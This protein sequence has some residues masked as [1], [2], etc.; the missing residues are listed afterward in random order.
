MI[1]IKKGLDIPIAGAPQQTIEDGESITTVAVLGEEYVGMRPTMHVKVEDRVKK[2]QVLFEDKKNPGVKFTAPAAGVVK[3]V[4]RGAKRV[5]QA[6][7]IEIDGDE[8]ETFAKYESKELANLDREKVVEQLNNSGQWVALRTRPFSRSPELDAEPVA[9]FVNAMDSNPLAGDPAVIIAEEQQ[10]FVDG[11]KVLSNLTKGKV[12][13]TKAADAKVET[14]DAEVQVESFKGPHPAGLVGTHIHFLEPVS[15]KRQVWHITYQDAIAY[16]KL[17]TTGE[18]YTGRVVAVGGPSVKNPRLLR[19]QMGAN[20]KE[21]TK[22]ELAD[23]KQ[24]IVSGSIL[25]GHKV[26][27]AHQWLGRFHMQVSVLPEGDEKEF[28]GWIKPGVDQHSVTRAF[29]GHLLP[30]K[31][32]T[33][34]TSTHG[35]D[36][37]MV[38][39]GNYERIMPLDILPT[40]LLR[41]LLSGDTDEAQQLGCLELDEEDLAL[42]TYVCPGKYE[43]GP[44]LRNVLT[45]IQKEEV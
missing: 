14:G 17:F 12:Y 5:L 8:Q 33:M 38:P 11:L 34:T 36:R 16:G 29:A 6:V 27:D 42:C 32:F 9:I 28:L 26:D 45:T 7:V 13:V 35:S 40:I 24:R 10:A 43:Y 41:D 19:T 4:L 18:I 44:V 22:G 39:I 1:T 31:L 21:L 23:G 20:L 30:K 3:D 15:V 37:A 25:N 2:G